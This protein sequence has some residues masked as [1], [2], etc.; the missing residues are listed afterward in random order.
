M[1]PV[2]NTEHEIPPRR[3]LFLAWF[4]WATLGWFGAHRFHLDRDNTGYFY[5]APIAACALLLILG[6]QFS[7]L[8]KSFQTLAVTCLLVC[9]FALWI[10]DFFWIAVTVVRDHAQREQFLATTEAE[11]TSQS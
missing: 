2:D 6:Q 10:F 4:I 5:L 7:A 8:F 11:K 9:L 1:P 3:H